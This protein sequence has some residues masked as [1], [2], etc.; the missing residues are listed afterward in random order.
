MT[1]DPLVAILEAELAAGTR[2]M[3]ALDR[4][5]EALIAR[6]LCAIEEISSDLEPLMAQFGI[7]LEARKRALDEDRQCRLLPPDLMQRV[8]QAEGRILRLAQLN[9]DLLADRLAYIGAMLAKLGLVSQV[10]Y[11]PE[12]ARSRPTSNAI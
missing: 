12:A 1:D 8:R 2:L 7:F 11:A 9:Q 6:D 4:Q 10:G 3:E 5:R